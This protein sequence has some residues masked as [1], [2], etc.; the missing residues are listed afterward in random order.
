MSA[1]Q[2]Y[3][4]GLVPVL[5]RKA[6]LEILESSERDASAI[7]ARMQDEVNTD[8]LVLKGHLHALKGIALNLGLDASVRALA[9]ASQH[10]LPEAILL[11]EK[12]PK[13]LAKELGEI[14]LRLQSL[15]A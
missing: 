7:I 15:S 13:L 6:A 12:I 3:L 11:K 4:E 1:E 8:L 5:G 14:R 10:S 9:D 2:S